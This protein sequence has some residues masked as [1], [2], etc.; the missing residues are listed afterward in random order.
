MISVLSLGTTTSLLGGV[1]GS[2]LITSDVLSSILSEGD[3]LP[4]LIEFVDMLD[5]AEIT[6]DP[7]EE[8]YMLLLEANEL[9]E[10]NEDDIDSVLESEGTYGAS[11]LVAI[12]PLA[13][14]VS[15][16]IY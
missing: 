13:G 8:L 14:L 2:E 16:V 6:E 11:R 10:G 12:A 3:E 7:A 15:L 5:D 4:P 9:D 1:T